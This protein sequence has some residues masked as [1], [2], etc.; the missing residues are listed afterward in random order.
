MSQSPDIGQNSD[1]GI[2][3]F[4][5]SGQS[6]IKENCHISRTIDD[7]DMKLGLG[8]RN[9]TSLRKFDDDLMSANCDAIAI[10]PVYG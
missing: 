7:I 8:K 5:I 2:S 4:L 1:G 3:D 10:F 6:L 9:K